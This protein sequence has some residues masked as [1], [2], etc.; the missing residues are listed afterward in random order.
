MTDVF[1]K[2]AL[3]KIAKDTGFVKRSSTV[4]GSN[5][6]E[7][8]LTNS[9]QGSL[10]SLE[11]LACNFQTNFG[12]QI[13]KQGLDERFNENTV[14]YLKQ[15]LNVLILQ[16]L[17]TTFH[18]RKE[19]HFEA[20]RLRDST[21]F[22]LPKEYKT[23]YKGQGGAVKSESM[24]SIQYE[25]DVISGNHID[26]Q[27]TSGCRNDQKDTIESIA[28]V[29]KGELLIRDLGYITTP[30]LNQIIDAEAFFLNRLPTKIS[31]YTQ[32]NQKI[33]FSKVYKILKQNKLPY[34]ELPVFL[35][36]KAQIPCRLV[37]SICKEEAVN[38]RLKKTTKNTKSNGYKVSQE[39]KNRAKLNM[40]ITNAPED[41]I[42]AQ[43]IYQLYT[44]RWQIE[45]IFKVW[46]SIAKI[47][48]VKKVKI[49]RFESILL[50]GLIWVLANWH[51]FQVIDRW[52]LSDKNEL[53]PLSIWK[54]Y[55]FTSKY[56]D[57][58][59]KTINS[60]EKIAEWL[61]TLLSIANTKLTRDFKKGSSPHIQRLDTLFIA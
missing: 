54:F 41:K 34:L 7:L 2:E 40:Y 3:D 23:V 48:Q 52:L 11:D 39:T 26:L 53:K 30:Y 36:K 25:F 19:P 49:H 16:K 45:L 37:V 12:K 58:F 59:F 46:K 9:T 43:D 10:L 51:V 27:L 31:V 15:V 60:R 17:N 32:E 61:S 38:K 18:Q 35:G 14:L 1:S 50:V 44:L 20:C 4:T 42:K 33:E 13:S 55:K 29:K 8:L 5:F 28:N 22:A 47:N 57:C 24:I 21:R 6:L 56:I